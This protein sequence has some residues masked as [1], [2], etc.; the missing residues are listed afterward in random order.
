MGHTDLVPTRKNLK[1][2]YS[3]SDELMHN[4]PP[5]NQEHSDTLSPLHRSSWGQWACISARQQGRGHCEGRGE[6]S[7]TCWAV[8]EDDW[9]MKPVETSRLAQ[10]CGTQSLQL[11]PT[12]TPVITPDAERWPRGE[13][14]Q[15]GQ[16]LTSSGRTDSLTP[17]S[18]WM[19]VA[20]PTSN[21]D[22][23]RWREP[24]EPRELA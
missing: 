18:F 9:L 21:W 2:V 19:C 16:L 23:G 4:C 8:N 3:V 6:G 1:C 24:R 17:M 20:M 22:T 5:S 15:T 13:G 12:Q 11:L 7:W 10:G 14:Q